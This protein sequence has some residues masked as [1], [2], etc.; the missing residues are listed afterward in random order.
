M[1]HDMSFLARQALIHRFQEL[2][3]VETDHGYVDEPQ[4]NLL[5]G[6]P[7]DSIRPDFERGQGGELNPQK[8]NGVELKPKFQAVYSSAALAVN[9]FGILKRPGHLQSFSFVVHVAPPGNR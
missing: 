2:T 6:I 8:R 3:G 9:S 1:H 7:R 4:R 5:L